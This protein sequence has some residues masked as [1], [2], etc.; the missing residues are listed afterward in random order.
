MSSVNPLNPKERVKIPRQHPRELGAETRRTSFLEVS[1]GFDEEQAVLEASRCLECRDP[2]CVKGCPVAVDIR[3]F[4]QSLVQRNFGAA[5]DRIRQTN[6]LPAICGR[7]C[8]QETQCEQVCTMGRR[9]E[10]VAI[11][12]LERFVA[13]WEARHRPPWDRAA[14]RPTGPRVA[15]VGSGPG[16]LTCAAELARM[17][18]AV[19]VF[20][21]L[22]ALGGVLRYGIPEFRLPNEVL[23]RELRLLDALGVQVHT[24]F[25]VGRTATLDEL[26][27]EEGFRAVFLAT[28]AGTPAF[29]GI[30][31]ESLSGSLSANEF[32]TRVN[33]M[34]A[35]RFPENDTPLRLGREVAV[36]GGGNTALD[37]VRTARRLGA[38][39]AYLVYRRSRAEMP[40]RKEEVAHAEEEGVEFLFLKNPTD[41]LGDERGRVRGLTC[42]DM[43]LGEPDASG[44]R[45]PVPVPGSEHV[46]AVQ[47][48]ISALGQRP[49]P[50]VQATTPGLAVGGNGTVTVDAEQRTSRPGVFAGGDLS[51]GGATV[52][53]AMRDGRQAAAA[54]HRYIQE[55]AAEGTGLDLGR[56]GN[57]RL[58]TSRNGLN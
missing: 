18:Y 14:K 48:V 34:G 36:V 41:I 17:G 43:T 6:A 22:H 56:Q 47:T 31:G 53:L 57:D 8:P 28:G 29:M 9:F 54:I 20:E 32:L 7:V 25:L 46:L 16:G 55:T 19:T 4:I 39:R 5:A 45:R 51:R 24:N 12:K 13:D 40:A 23:D 50:I 52:I 11:G 21:A 33:L 38:E 49:N 58:T 1:P 30:P 44:R 26:M 35:D 42:Q 27:E 10:P 3:G 15:V 2:V 37:A